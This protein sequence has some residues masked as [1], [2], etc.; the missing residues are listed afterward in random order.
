MNIQLPAILT[1]I[2]SSADGGLRMSFA[3][4][5]L[6]PEEKVEAM[7]LHQQFGWLLFSPNPF[8]SSDLPKEQAEEGQKSPS[9]RLRATL[10]ILWKQQGEQGD[11]EVFYRAKMEKIID[12]IKAK[13][14]EM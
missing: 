1:S 11:F 10:F 4:N 9:K 14:D 12:M 7:K 8:T 3:T 13:L 5:E 2:S 6:T